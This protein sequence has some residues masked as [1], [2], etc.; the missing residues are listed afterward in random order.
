MQSSGKNGSKIQ[1][2]LS[3]C[4][5]MSLGKSVESVHSSSLQHSV[6]VFCF[7]SQKDISRLR[8]AKESQIHP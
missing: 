4:H 5:I 3:T 6:K 2:F 1:Y 7:L 8:E